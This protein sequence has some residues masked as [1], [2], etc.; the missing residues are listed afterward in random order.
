MDPVLSTIT[1]LDH[2]EGTTVYALV[3]GVAQGPFTVVGGTIPGNF[4]PAIEKGFLEKIASGV[5]AGYP[6]QNICVEVH[7]GKDHPVDSNETAF[8]RNC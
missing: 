7:F 1:G 3:N 8:R 5:V 6:V 4:M 2:F